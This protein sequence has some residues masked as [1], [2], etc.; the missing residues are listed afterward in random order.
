MEAHI[1]K[2]Q[3]YIAGYEIKKLNCESR[4]N[5]E[6]GGKFASKYFAGSSLQCNLVSP[7]MLS[8]RNDDFKSS[9]TTAEELVLV[10]TRDNDQRSMC[11]SS[12]NSS[13]DWAAMPRLQNK[14]D[15]QLFMKY[16]ND[17]D[18]SI[19]HDKWL[20]AEEHWLLVAVSDSAGRN[21]CRIADAV[22]EVVDSKRRTP[23]QCLQHYQL[24][25][26]R[27]LVKST[28]WSEHEERVLMAAAEL[29]GTKRTW[30]HISNCLEG[31]AASQCYL[32]WKR[33]S[34]KGTKSGSW[35]DMEERR[36]V[37][38]VV[39]NEKV[40][41]L[42]EHNC[43]ANSSSV[44][45]AYSSH[46]IWQEIC[47]CVPQRDEVRCREKWSNVLDPK[48][49]DTS[50]FSAEEDAI[51]LQEARNCTDRKTP[52]GWSAIANKLTGR[53]DS[54]CLRRWKELSGSSAS[55]IYV[56]QSKKRRAIG[57]PRHSR[58]KAS[59]SSLDDN[60]F[61]PVLSSS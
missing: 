37:F 16:R 45:N 19:N 34:S 14:T 6:N 39:A 8:Y 22:S 30:Q 60:S 11:S 17:C 35:N 23:M 56:E 3:E 44:N 38:G 54:Q 55:K 31:R 2:L 50:P 15:M 32:R 42:R 13:C 20:P 25:F 24:N 26:N 18:P 5:F 58:M 40:M 12:T 7:P 51:I 46:A 36:L 48:S 61:L 1:S 49:V 21:W 43:V 28:D 57:V 9:Y 41:R 4:Q 53:T 52:V 59:R 10:N 47:K 33:L 29:Y 27:A